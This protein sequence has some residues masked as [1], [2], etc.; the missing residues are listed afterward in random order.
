VVRRVQADAVVTNG[1]FTNV[2]VFPDPGRETWEMHLA[3]LRASMKPSDA[4]N[5]TRAPIDKFTQTLMSPVW[6]SYFGTLFQYGG[7]NPP[8]F[9][10]SV[11]AS[12]QCVDAAMKDLNNGVL[13]ET[14][15]RSLANCHVDGHDPSP[16]VN[17]ISS[18]DIK[19]GDP[20]LT[21]N[22]SDICSQI[23]NHT[24]AYH[25]GGLNTPNF[26]AL[27]TAPGCAPNF[28][29]YTESV[30]HEDVEMLSDPG[31]TGHG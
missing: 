18:P 22:G 5:F 10:G 28:A 17:P 11:V 16:Q 25:S 27:P 29:K 6:P 20:A 1:K 2:Y 21:T 19:I 14:T 31:A 4:N 8:G 3:R 12:Q 9:F 30:S 24:V 7:I 15:I 13:E 26:A 23:G